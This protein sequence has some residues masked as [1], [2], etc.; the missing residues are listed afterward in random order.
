MAKKK[1]HYGETVLYKAVSGTRAELLAVAYFR[2]HG[3]RYAKAARELHLRGME[4]FL[5]SLTPAE[6][7][8]YDQI[9][10]SVR[11]ADRLQSEVDQG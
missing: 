6:R 9:M 4:S 5:N 8:R 10:E 2:G 7:R 3:S 1:V 11:L